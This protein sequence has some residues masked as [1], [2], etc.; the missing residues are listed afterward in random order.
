[1]LFILDVPERA[2]MGLVGWSTT[3]M[4]APYQHITGSIR[5]DIAQCV[6]GLLWGPV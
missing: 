3:A 1:V 5:G 4:P 6:G 2:V